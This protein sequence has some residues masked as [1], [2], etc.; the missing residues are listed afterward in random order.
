M[1]TNYQIIAA[2]TQ[3]HYQEAR[4]LTYAYQQFIGIDLEFQ[5]F[6]TEMRTLPQMYGPPKGVM[7]LVEKKEVFIGCAGLRDFGDNIA[8]M[9]RMYVLPEHQGKGIGKTLTKHLIGSARKLG[10]NAIRL[11]S[12]PWMETAISMYRKF[13]FIEIPAYR[14]NPDKDTVYLELKL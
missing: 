12:L 7:F 9:K 8:E 11:D 3:A 5:G 14:Y 6:S 4:K 1:D 2:T 10:Y 13:G